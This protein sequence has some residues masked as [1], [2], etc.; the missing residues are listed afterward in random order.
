MVEHFAMFFWSVLTC[1]RAAS[2][3]TFVKASRNQS[4]IKYQIFCHVF[5]PNT[6]P[7]LSPSNNQLIIKFD[8]LNQLCS[9]RAKIKTCTQWGPQE[10][11]WE[12]LL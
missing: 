9:A 4:D 8:Y 5:K 1:S 12:T 2:L 3:E 11:V 6:F 10:W 7:K